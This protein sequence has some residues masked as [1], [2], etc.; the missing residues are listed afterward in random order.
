MR[1]DRIRET[2][3]ACLLVLGLKSHRRATLSH[4]DPGLS[5]SLSARKASSD[6]LM[7]GGREALTQLPPRQT[8]AQAQSTI[9]W[10][11]HVHKMDSSCIVLISKR[12]RLTIRQKNKSDI[13]PLQAVV[14]IL[15][16][17]HASDRHVGCT[18]LKSRRTL[19]LHKAYHIRV[20]LFVESLVSSPSSSKGRDSRRKR[21]EQFQC[22]TTGIEMLE[23]MLIKGSAS[24]RET[25]LMTRWWKQIAIAGQTSW[26]CR[27]MQLLAGWSHHWTVCQCFHTWTKRNWPKQ[28]RVQSDTQPDL[29]RVCWEVWEENRLARSGTSKVVNWNGPFQV[30]DPHHNERRLKHTSRNVQWS[31]G[32]LQHVIQ[33]YMLYCSNE[34]TD[35]IQF[36]QKV[37]LSSYRCY[38]TKC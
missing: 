4:E 2:S 19:N 38:I 22:Q 8:W 25:A 17:V 30:G 9:T 20:G 34:L 3:F 27:E 12:F 26:L 35:L 21:G 36:Y 37:N 16:L 29:D 28:D 10:L 13:I 24:E 15:V 18:T 5:P 32:L 14:W 6:A 1:T 33:Y 7:T 11:A 23:L 31:R